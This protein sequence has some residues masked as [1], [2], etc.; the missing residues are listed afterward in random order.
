MK[1]RM[2]KL[3]SLICVFVII[4]TSCFIFWSNLWYY[5]KDIFVTYEDYNG[6]QHSRSNQDYLWI[7]SRLP[8]DYSESLH[9]LNSSG[10]LLYPVTDGTI[11]LTIRM[12]TDDTNV[13]RLLCVLLRSASIYWDSTYGPV[14]LILDEKDEESNFVEKLNNDFGDL[15]TFRA[16]YEKDP[17][18]IDR[19]RQAGKRAGRPIGKY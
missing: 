14:H 6:N 15:F 9:F 1:R 12:P 11:E 8:V 3:C 4:L 5:V 18:N 2:V 7:N 19:F 17:R 16:T 10:S 13:G